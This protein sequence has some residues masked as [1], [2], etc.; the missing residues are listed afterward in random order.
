MNKR[1]LAIDMFRGLTMILMVFVNDFWSVFNVPHF[2]EHFDTLEDGMGLSDVIFPL[3][4]FAMGM[5]IPYAIDRRYEKG[6]STQSTLGHI[7]VRTLALILMGLFIYNGEARVLAGSRALYIVLYLVGFFLVWNVYPKGWKAAR[8]LQLSGIVLLTV[9]ALTYRDQDGGL[10]Q[11]GW[12]GILGLIGWAYLFC[13]VAYLLARPRIWPL[14][15]CWVFFG[16]VNLLGT[17]MRSGETLVG[18]NFLVEISQALGQGNGHITFM[19]LGGMLTT[20]L[21]RKYFSGQWGAGM[22]I[23]LLLALLG[24]ATHQG[25]IISKNLGTLPWC[26]FVS[27][28]AVAFYTLLRMLEAKGWT[29]WFKP[30]SVAGTSTLTLYMVPYVFIVL[31]ILLEPSVPDWLTG[32]VGIGKC[33]LYTA[34]CLAVAWALTRLGIK[35]KI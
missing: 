8:W 29:G 34:L 5:S 6:A 35:L 16:I 7:L 21:E 1:N 14:A 20:L 24:V 28:I 9:L 32:W 12:W 23:A 31:W 3:F 10:F 33:A 15:L 11:T 22:G 26:L 27:A 25:W 30:L 17:P 2:L 13:A 4:L 19:A 18:P